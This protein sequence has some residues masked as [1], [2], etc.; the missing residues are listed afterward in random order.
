MNFNF[1]IRIW[2]TT[3]LVLGLIG[4]SAWASGRTMYSTVIQSSLQQ[5]DITASL[6]ATNRVSVAFQNVSNIT[7]NL[8]VTITNVTSVTTVGFKDEATG[9]AD[10]PSWQQYPLSPSSRVTNGGAPKAAPNGVINLS[11]PPLG[12]A[13]ASWSLFCNFTDSYP[14]ITSSTGDATDWVN[15]SDIRNVSFTSNFSIQVSV[16]EDRG[17]VLG[18][19]TTQL[20]VFTSASLNG[21]S[22]RSSLNG[23]RPF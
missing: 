18:D 23:G 15:N 6:G 12:V 10:F 9:R 4:D 5:D 21:P 3:V 16:A 7:Q 1:R 14:C 20:N 22:S 19:I 13:F 8:T 17:A 11:I 2:V